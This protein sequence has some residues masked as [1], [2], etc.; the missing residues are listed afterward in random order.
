MQRP[1]KMQFVILV[2]ENHALPHNMEKSFMSNGVSGSFAGSPA[3]FSWCHT[4]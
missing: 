2:K 3:W 1:P 4:S